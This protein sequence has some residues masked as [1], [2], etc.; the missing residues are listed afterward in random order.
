M[1]SGHDIDEDKPF[2]GL[3]GDWLLRQFYKQPLCQTDRV[4][5]ECRR[6]SQQHRELTDEDFE[7]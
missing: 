1:E 6:K 4:A 7:G 5:N 2:V 3:L